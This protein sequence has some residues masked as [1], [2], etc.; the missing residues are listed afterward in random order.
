MVVSMGKT[1]AEIERAYTL[2]TLDILGGN[3]SRAAQVLGIGKK[4]LYRRLEE[5]GML[6]NGSKKA[7][8]GQSA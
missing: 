2:K 6:G 3:K 1:L 8:A 7:T 5:Y 4:T